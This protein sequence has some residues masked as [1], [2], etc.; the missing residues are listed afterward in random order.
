MVVAGCRGLTWGLPA[1]ARVALF[2]PGM[3]L[4][5]ILSSLRKAVRSNGRKPTRWK[6]SATRVPLMRRSSALEPNR[7]RNDARRGGGKEGDKLSWSGLNLNNA[8]R[9]AWAIGCYP[10]AYP[11]VHPPYRRIRGRRARDS[12][13]RTEHK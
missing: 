11:A 10:K 8:I 4:A 6:M 5:S 13:R 2:V 1:T 7:L 9:A 3:C 12:W